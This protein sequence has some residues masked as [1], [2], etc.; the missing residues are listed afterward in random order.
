[1]T[2]GLPPPTYEPLGNAA[3][4]CKHIVCLSMPLVVFVGSVAVW[5]LLEQ[6]GVEQGDLGFLGVLQDHLA[7]RGYS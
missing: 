2:P 3:E 7:D 5:W 1:M 4:A 6:H